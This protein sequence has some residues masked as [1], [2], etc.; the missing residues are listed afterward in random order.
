MSKWLIVAVSVF[1]IASVTSGC[2][3]KTAVKTEDK[4][5]V[6]TPKVKEPVKP[7]PVKEEP[8]KE[9]TTEQEEE[10]EDEE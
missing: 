7:E 2:A 10:T 8:V 1:F 3:K 9:D 6:F 5:K 4:V